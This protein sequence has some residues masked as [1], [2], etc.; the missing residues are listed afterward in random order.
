MA[1][2]TLLS[3]IAV[4]AVLMGCAHMVMVKPPPIDAQTLRCRTGQ[5]CDIK[6]YVRCFLFWCEASVDQKLVVIEKG[7]KDVVIRWELQDPHYKF[8]ANG[9][10]FVTPPLPPP[11]E[12]KCRILGPG[13]QRF[14]CVD[15]HDTSGIWKYNVN[16]IGVRTLDPWA[17]NE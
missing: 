13:D 2:K 17:A 16:V 10:E 3:A 11:N 12:F 1:T 6:V 9:I 7:Q 4:A 14:Q 5:S 8:A 15:A